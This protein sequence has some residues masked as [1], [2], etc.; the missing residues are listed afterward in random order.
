MG[1]RSKRQ[2]L[3]M[4]CSLFSGVCLPCVDLQEPVIYYISM[5][6]YID[7]LILCIY[8]HIFMY[9]LVRRYRLYM[10]VCIMYV[11]VVSVYG[12]ICIYSCI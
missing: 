12:Y 2:K 8:V 10:Y 9:A 5:R 7:M 11:C 1:E 3:F 4:T 6:E